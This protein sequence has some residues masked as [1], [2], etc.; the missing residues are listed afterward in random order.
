MRALQSLAFAFGDF[1]LIPEERLL[2]RRGEPVALTAKAFDLLVVLVRRAGH[3]V[4]KDELFDEVW[5]GTFVQETNL[6]VNISALR[7]ALDDGRDG[8]RII[9]TVP[10]RGYRFVAPVVVRDAVGDP[11]LRPERGPTADGA[12]AVQPVTQEIPARR[13]AGVSGLAWVLLAA[14]GCVALVAMALWR[15]QPAGQNVTFASVAVLPFLSD[16]PA[17]NY[18]AD[19]LSEA[20]VNGLVQ[21]EGLRVAP[22]A[23]ALRYKGTAV[24]PKQAGREL[25]VAAV[26]T[27]SV[28]QRD[29]S[30]R[31][32]IDL[33]D[34]ARDAQI[35]GTVYRSDASELPHLQTRI[36]QDL[37]QALKGP[38]SEPQQRRLSQPATG[39]AEAYRAY[40]QARFEWSQRSEDG[41]KRAIERFREAVAIDPTFAA[42]YAGLA[43][44]YSAL[45]YLSYLAPADAFPEARRHATSALE[46]D[47]SLADAHA[48]LGFVKL[49]FDWDWPGAEAEFRRAIALDPN[50]PGPHQWYSIYLLAAGR[51]REALQA[52]EAAQQR[53]PLSLAVNT[54]LGFHYYYTRR[55]DEAV[56]QLVLVLHMNPNFPPAH[57]WLGRTYQELGNFDDALT[58]FARVEER[59]RD[60]PVAIAARGFVAG[61]SGR[62]SEA[63]EV[64]V[65]LQQLAD[66]RF[67]TSY[68][69][70]L[71]YAGLGDNDTA[72]AA[73]EKAFDERSNWLVWL[74][75]DPR[76]KG[77]RSDPRFSE[78]V[79][80]MRFPP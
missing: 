71:V 23:S 74:R 48:S 20:T 47:P 37:A 51:P 36:L 79:S 9:Q 22:R 70:A 26:V 35:L 38:L 33:V 5:P 52:I 17:S 16:S 25:D 6:T 55:Y 31:I 34:V 49:Y 7:K 27:A 24:S 40:L 64:V 3:L 32:Q 2:L 77:L 21:M 15:A 80:R 73:L 61:V 4:T 62:T 45:G 43:D 72:F 54:D 28:T 59:T 58:A 46:L 13:V 68:G 8:S 57:L 78:L 65:E 30:L 56:K 66:K 42:A 69:V 11:L 12:S 39:S 53:D 29:R 41:L 44:A 75:L 10:G 67:V 60:W 18:L 63:R 19:G 1:L 50:Q 76:W 14:V